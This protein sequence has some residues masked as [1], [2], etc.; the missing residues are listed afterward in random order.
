MDGGLGTSQQ[1]SYW[2]PKL[3]EASYNEANGKYF[4]A[5]TDGNTGCL[6]RGCG[7]PNYEGES[8]Y[9]LGSML[10][11]AGG[12]SSFSTSTQNSAQPG[13]GALTTCE[14]WY[15]PANSEFANA[16]QLGTPSGAYYVRTIGGNTVY[17]RD[18]AGGVVLVNPSQNSISSFSPTPGGT[19][20]GSG[21]SNVTSVTMGPDQ[22]LILLRTG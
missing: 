4:V 9:G 18:F 7:S 3:A 17:E 13:C 15:G 12:Y 5:L 6:V 22:S 19:Y 2:V 21:L 11:V 16:Q 8:T 10:L 1:D 14:A 20:S